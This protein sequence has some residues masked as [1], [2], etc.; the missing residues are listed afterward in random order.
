MG[1]QIFWIEFKSELLAGQFI[2]S[3]LSI[4]KQILSLVTTALS[5]KNLF[6]VLRKGVFSRIKMVT[7]KSFGEGIIAGW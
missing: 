4:A 3:F 2:K 6:L 7:G 1:F 5:T